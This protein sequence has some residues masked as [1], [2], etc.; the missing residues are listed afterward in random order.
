MAIKL[1]MDSLFRGIFFGVSEEIKIHSQILQMRTAIFRF[2]MFGHAEH[3]ACRNSC[4][5]EYARRA[6]RVGISG[7]ESQQQ[8]ER[9]AGHI[10]KAFVNAC[11]GTLKPCKFSR[12]KTRK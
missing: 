4:H 2:A 6:D 12:P 3:T 11:F 7:E 9:P 10:K 1:N 5:A 8:D